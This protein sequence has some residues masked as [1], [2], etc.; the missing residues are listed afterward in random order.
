[1]GA[2]NCRGFLIRFEGGAVHCP[3]DDEVRARVIAH[4][5]AHVHFW[6]SDPERAETASREDHE[7]AARQQQETWGFPPLPENPE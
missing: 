6:A 3:T 7:R 1:M 4:E 2:V 5:L